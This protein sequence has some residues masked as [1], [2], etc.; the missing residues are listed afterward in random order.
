MAFR[1]T[2]RERGFYPLFTRAA[3]NIARAADDLAA[4]VAA[5][6]REGHAVRS[7]GPPVRAAHR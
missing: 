2:P 5:P 4:L 3:E 1:L 7:P 6:Q